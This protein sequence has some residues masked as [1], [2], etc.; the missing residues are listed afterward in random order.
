MSNYTYL[1]VLAEGQAER[2]FAQKTLGLHLEPLG[3]LVDSRC[4]TTS[5]KQHKKGGLDNYLKVKN[6]LQRWINEEKGR[7]PFFTTMFDLYALPNDFPSFAESLQISD[8]YQR[9]EFLEKAFLDDI[10]FH[11]FIPYLQ[12]HEFEA[13]LLANPEVLLLEYIGAEAQ[14]EKLK[15]IVAD[16]H[17][18]P[19]E[20]NTGK[21]TAPSKRI[22]SLI[23]E[24][25]GNKVSVG[26]VLAGIEGIEAQRERCKHF[27]D[28]VN[29]LKNISQQVE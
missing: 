19:E 15:K 12:L 1:N 21:T 26:A 25:E 24:Y 20:I 13:L 11:K 4:V 7:R 6:D 28:W 22:I 10:D 9:V 3:I 5:R 17:N 29:K 27:A 23:P 16:H 14:V 18:N 8:P 2:E